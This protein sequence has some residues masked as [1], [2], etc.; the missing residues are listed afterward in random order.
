MKEPAVEYFYGE[1]LRWSFGFENPNKAAVLFACVMPLL[2][3]G[4]VAAWR[5]ESKRLKAC[6]VVLLGVAFLTAG[7]WLCMT[8]SRGGLVAALVGI[9]Y[10]IQAEFFTERRKIS[11]SWI[12]QQCL[13]GC[14][15]GVVF[16]TGLAARSRA[17]AE[18]DRAVSNRVELWKGALQ[19]SVE[20]PSGFGAGNSGAVYMQ[21][22]QDPDAVGKYRTMVNSY[23]TFLVERGWLISVGVIVIFVM[24]WILTVPRRK[25]AVAHG[26]RGV[27]LAFLVAGIFSTTM[28]DWRLWILPCLT[29][30][31]LGLSAFFGGETITKRTICLSGFGMVFVLFCLTIYGL[32][33]SSV[34]SLKRTFEKGSLVSI[35][36]RAG[37][38]AAL[39]LLP[40][41]KV[42]GPLYGKL[43]RELVKESGLKVILGN[44][45]LDQ[46]RV[47]LVGDQIHTEIRPRKN[48]EVILLSPETTN[49]EMLQKFFRRGQNIKL[50]LAEI[51]EDDRVDSWLKI[52]AE[53][54]IEP[55]ILYGVGTRVDWAWTE[56]IEIFKPDKAR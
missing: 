5:M 44:Q 3:W 25:F 45:A 42:L 50:I 12:A 38:R 24:F 13:L 43:V 51:G 34:D 18:G 47:M 4:W 23:L 17:V 33:L 21:W 9:I 7:Y 54:K 16:W 35:E 20:N 56:V 39:G 29:G 52:A 26:L 19:M 1:A 32:Y 8:F 10:V 28:E 14:F 37:I 6:G 31:W 40:D 11:R 53:R 48:R 30:A 27:I 41:P 46:G 22:Y 36:K 55:T 2:W 15:F 49:P